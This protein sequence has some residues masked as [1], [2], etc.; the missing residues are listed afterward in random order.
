M[1]LSV[2]VPVYNG[3]AVVEG[4][5]QSLRPQV[6]E[7]CEV[8]VVDDG[9]SDGTPEILARHGWIKTV[10][11]EVNR[12]AGAARNSGAWAACGEVLLFLDADTQAMP[13][14]LSRVVSFFA[15]RPEV[16]AA[17]GIYCERNLGR[18]A[19]ARYLDACQSA[20]RAASLDAAAPG[21]LSGSLCAIRQKVFRSAGGFS[22]DRRLALEDIELGLRLTRA[23]YTHWLVGDWRVA[24]HQP[25]LWQQLKELVPRSRHYVTLLHEFGAYNEIM[26][27]RSEGSA[28]LSF[29]ASCLLLPLTLVMPAWSTILPLLMVA[30][31]STWLNRRWLLTCLRQEPPSFLPAA[32][33]YHA[34]TTL[35][36]CL[37]TG[38]GVVDVAKQAILRR[39]I[40]L[41]VVGRY[42]KS[43]LTPGAGGYLIQFLTHRCPAQCS[44]CFDHPQ[45]AAIERKNELSIERI[46]QIAASAG[47]LGHVSLTGGEP[48]LRDDL[49]QIL[50]AWYRAGV[51]SISLSTSGAYP[52][53][54]AAVL[55]QALAGM[56]LLRLMITISVDALD[57][58]H[59][60]LRGMPGLFAKVE[61]TLSRMQTLRTQWPQLRLHAC[62]TL[63][64]NNLDDAE[65]TLAWLAL[66]HCDEIE[67]NLLRGNPADSTMTPPAEAD[68][69][70]IRA[71]AEKL[72]GKNAGLGRLFARADRAMHRIVR[73]WQQPWP[74]G[75][76]LAGKRLAVILADGDVLPCEML[77][78]TRV[79]DAQHFRNFS[80]GNL[81]AHGDNLR[82][83][84]ASAQAQRITDYIE[85]TQCRCSFECAIFAT[86]AY[87]PWRV[88]HLLSQGQAAE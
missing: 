27:G 12:G 37:G 60:A 33:G 9:S 40:D 76:C 81:G 20:M 2:I 62:L 64:S 21:T 75:S 26:G 56:P 3:A 59:D 13:E 41:A 82:T 58:R 5:L 23:G 53:K 49:P 70:R 8:I 34:A 71:L 38:R 63:T 54:L 86:M 61:Q 88:L 83:L 77:R 17:S 66:W 55:A 46:R 28:R 51:R 87:R 22:E 52:E 45:R 84:M 42:L 4:Q 31:L 79:R 16:A 43:L 6:G 74:C 25:Q 69:S 11:H 65:Q 67:L 19:F 7:G 30:I 78:T 73:N 14:L 47:A 29:I 48:L 36:I 24:H 57:A 39:R 35:A 85:S 80:L 50:L 15:G 72:N 44:H 1:N 10:R 18:H 32:L 68:Y